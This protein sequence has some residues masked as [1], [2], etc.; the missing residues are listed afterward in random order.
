[1]SDIDLV[2]QAVARA[3]MR[4]ADGTL[5]TTDHIEHVAETAVL[6]FADNLITSLTDL[7]KEAGQ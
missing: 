3:R 1:M 5:L 6:N 2:I 4:F 7:R